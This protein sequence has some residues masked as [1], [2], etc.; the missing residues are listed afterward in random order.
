MRD[1]A[2]VQVGPEL[3]GVPGRAGVASVGV[4]RPEG[5]AQATAQIALPRAEQPP[6]LDHR[7]VGGAVVHRAVVPGVDVPAE[8]DEAI[9]LAAD[10]GGQDRDRAPAGIDLGR[11][12]DAQIACC[13]EA[14]QVPRHR[15]R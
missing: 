10:L 4:P 15:R 5:E 11:D 8:E 7:R 14:A 9:L 6:D 2:L 13:G 1:A 3:V 12:A